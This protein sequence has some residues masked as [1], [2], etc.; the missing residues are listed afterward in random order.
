MVTGAWPP[1][2]FETVP[3][4][5]AQRGGTRADRTVAEITVAIPPTV[6]EADVS[7]D[8]ALVAD[9]EEALREVVALDTSHAANLGALG[10]LLLRTESVASSKIEAIDASID[11]YARALHGGRANPAASA[12]AAATRALD[13]M[14]GAVGRRGR[15]DLAD[16]HPR[17]PRA[18][19]R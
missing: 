17:T 4:L 11:D 7:I 18:H 3:W 2:R 6:A 5:Q 10:A 8:A 9:S 14:V 19:A 16:P 1:H 15:L 12:M 13:V